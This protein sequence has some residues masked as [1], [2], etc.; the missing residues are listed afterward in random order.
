IAAIWSALRPAARSPN[1]NTTIGAH[2]LT[3]VVTDARGADVDTGSEY[4]PSNSQTNSV[5]GAMSRTASNEPTMS[6]TITVAARAKAPNT[7]SG[8]RATRACH[9]ASPR[10]ATKVRIKSAVAGAP[11]SAANATQSLLGH[12]FDVIPSSVLLSDGSPRE[13]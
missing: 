9:A 1:T 8:L 2:R 6:V 10:K 13:A 12:G 3:P 11:R 7:A 4:T 5:G